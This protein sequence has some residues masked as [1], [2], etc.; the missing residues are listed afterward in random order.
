MNRQNLSGLIFGDSMRIGM[1]RFVVLVE[2][3]VLLF[4]FNAFKGFA[5]R[6]FPFLNTLLLM[7]FFGLIGALATA[8][9][10]LKDIYRYDF[11]KV[12][13]RYFMICFFGMFTPKI[14]VNHRMED[15]PWHETV[16]KIGGPVYM[17]V[18]PGYVVLT[19][20]LTAPEKVYGQ[21]K[22]RFLS[23]R[24]RIQ[25]MVDLREQE[26]TVASITANTKDGI[27]VTVKETKF[28]YRIWDP[29]WDV[30]YRENKSERN[31]YPYSPQAIRDFVYNRPVQMSLLNQP[32]QVS[33]E[34]AVRGKVSGI[35]RGYIS[36]HK[37]DEIIAPRE[38]LTH[39]DRDEVVKEGY[40]PKFKEGL[41]EFGTI[42]RWW[43]PGA[44]SSEVDVEKQ[45]IANWGVKLAGD[46]QISQ[47]HGDAQQ[48]AYEELGRA[49]AEAEL[50]VSIINA[51]DGLPLGSDKIRTMQ[52]LI[53]LRTAQVIKALGSNN[54]LPNGTKE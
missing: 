29:R 6:Y 10:Y 11:D 8:V 52:N 26:S 34:S 25:A 13:F 43:D 18:D 33:W 16:E 1:I 19:E 46:I 12:P 31:P 7:Y 21:G 41:R 53:L 4:L 17:D 28:N 49:E 37:L 3:P 40:D 36:K 30:L 45:H 2:I 22:K 50:L 24:E 5:G 47:A 44:F 35:I 51:M 27:Q 39:Q 14:R 32:E 15:S 54:K 42:L 23:R 20:S 48:I 38:N 9:Y